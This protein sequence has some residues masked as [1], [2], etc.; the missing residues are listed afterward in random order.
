MGGPRRF[1]SI[2]ALVLLSACAVA[3]EK[4]SKIT[5]SFPRVV[6]AA[7]PFYPEL[8]RQTHI[9]GNVT[10]RVSTDGKHVL[11]AEAE[12]GPGLLVNAVK[13]NVKTWE[14]E[15]HSP[16]SFEV[17]FDYALLPVECDSDCNCD[18]KEKESVLLRLPVHAEVSAKQLMLC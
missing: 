17:T 13:E 5:A 10:L 4:P 6:S 18:S 16:T 2:L 7:V 8:A 14:F 3:Q 11:S 9:A 15:P 12:N 1:A